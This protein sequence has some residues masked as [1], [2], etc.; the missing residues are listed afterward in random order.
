M[1]QVYARNRKGTPFDP[2]DYAADL[3]DK[4]SKF[5]ADEKYVPKKYRFLYG[6]R[7]IDHVDQLVDL[8]FDAN[9]INTKQHPELQEK[10]KEAWFNARKQCRK[11][12]RQIARL[13]N[14]CPSADAGDMTQILELLNKEDE[15]LSKA[16]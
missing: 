10:R 13:I 15:A 2:L 16:H 9:E 7:I 6:V 5:I 14:I 3:Q 4:L 11:L 12:D 8:A 1:S